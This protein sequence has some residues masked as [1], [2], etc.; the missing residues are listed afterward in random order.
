MIAER[1]QIGVALPDGREERLSDPALR[2]PSLGGREALQPLG[3]LAARRLR[4]LPHVL[5]DPSRSQAGARRGGRVDDRH[6]QH[7]RPRPGE[8]DRLSKGCVPGGR[9]VDARNHL[10][11]DHRAKRYRTPPDPHGSTAPG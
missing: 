4:L 7:A 11:V 1:E 3:G 9:S 8:P 5:N 10:A 2:D 6:G